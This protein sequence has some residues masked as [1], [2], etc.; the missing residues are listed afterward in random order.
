MAGW[1]YLKTKRHERKGKQIEK[2]KKNSRFIGREERKAKRRIYARQKSTRTIDNILRMDNG[3]QVQQQAE[4][5]AINPFMRRATRPKF[6]GTWLGEMRKPRKR[7]GSEGGQVKRKIRRKKK[8][9]GEN[10]N[11]I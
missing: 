1:R 4:A 9:E 3:I 10:F 8:E 6:F 7:G 11:S 2:L 5:G